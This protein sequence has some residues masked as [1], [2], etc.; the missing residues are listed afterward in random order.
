MFSCLFKPAILRVF[1]KLSGVTKI[2][3]CNNFVFMANCVL[4]FGGADMIL[5]KAWIFFI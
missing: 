1:V 4:S 3:I 2:V 5:C